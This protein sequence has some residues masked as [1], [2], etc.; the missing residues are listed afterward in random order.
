MRLK[1]G[2]TKF[3]RFT[4]NEHSIR[5][6]KLGTLLAEVG[7]GALVIF[8][9]S[10]N[11]SNLH[12]WTHYLPRSS[13]YFV[14]SKDLSNN[15]LLI[16]TYNH[17]PTAKEM[18]IVDDIGW[19]THSHSEA[20]VKAT[21]QIRADGKRKI[22]IIGKGFPYDVASAISSKLGVELVNL[23]SEANQIR[24]IKSEEEINWLKKAAELTDFSM[25]ALAT[26][27]SSGMREY[28][29]AD[30]VEHAYLPK[31]GTTRIHY[32]GSTSMIRPEIYVPSQYQ[33]SRR[34][35]KGDVVIT[36]LSAEFG[37]YAGQIHRPISIGE[38]PT[39]NY[40]RLYDAALDAY[41]EVLSQLKDGT[42]SEEL[43]KAADDAIVRKGYT[44]CDSLVH[45]FGTE[46][47]FPELGTSN[48]VY[49]N[50]HYEYKEN[51]AVVI[52]PNPITPDKKYGLQLGNLC[53]VGKEKSKSL[54]KFP[55]KFLQTRR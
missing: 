40:S 36:E 35:R 23:T 27:L 54:Q 7:A 20:V 21:G 46:L 10:G 47:A 38:K 14:A 18:S 48:S 24:A 45:G 49:A 11:T 6:K 55:I 19:A 33:T 2:S 9:S 39:G 15:K 52:Q 26:K 25:S 5:N 29:M 3:P 22:A 17:I 31:G 37:G 13:S 32:M 30:I 53:L 41:E 50:P 8:G 12:Y 43:I 34:L 4:K 16:G 51:M 44:I 42:T 28:E 1:L